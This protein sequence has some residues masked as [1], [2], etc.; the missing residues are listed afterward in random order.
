MKQQQPIGIFDSGYGGLTVLEQIHKQMPKYDLLYLGDNAR[1]PYGTRS[2]QVI[3]NYT[4][5]AVDRLFQLG[6]QLI[7]LACN[8]ASAKALRSIQQN[9]LPK[10]YPSRRVLGVI[11]PSVEALQKHSVTGHIGIFATPGTVR[12]VSYPLE[13]AKLYPNMQV[14]QEACPMW[15]PLVENNE[16]NTEGAKFF[17]KKHVQNILKKDDKIDVIILG[18]T[19]YPILAKLIKQY[20]P[21]HIKLITQ[22][23]IV[24]PSLQSYLNR[25]PEME[26]KCSKNGIST[27]LTTET[28]EIFDT[29]ATIFLNKKIKAINIETFL[30]S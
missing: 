23:N 11:R 9:Y 5:E 7:I 1:T 14:T 8:T 17:V 12:S 24:A 15:V 18:C 2:F 25:H 21:K 19:H 20:L 3:Y 30:N 6:C 28:T 22:G 29:R 10:H 13:I 26:Q 27:F 16:Y 4:K